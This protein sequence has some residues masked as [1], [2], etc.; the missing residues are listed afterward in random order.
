MCGAPAKR[1]EITG[2]IRLLDDAGAYASSSEYLTRRGYRVSTS[3]D[4]RDVEVRLRCETSHHVLL[5][6]RIGD[7]T[8]MA[9][10]RR[11]RAVSGVLAAILTRNA[12]Q[13]ERIIDLEMGADDEV[14][15]S[16]AH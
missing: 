3:R 12:D 10:L 2:R 7:V 8:G 1:Q 6:Q 16:V 11:I 5:E 4:A 13:V 9:I 15:K 14:Y